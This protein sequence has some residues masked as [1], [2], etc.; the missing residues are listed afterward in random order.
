MKGAPPPGLVVAATASGAGMT[1]AA[2][3]LVRALRAAGLDVRAAKTGPDFIDTAFLAVASGAPAANLD[4]WMCRPGSRGRPRVLPAGLGRLRR[5]LLGP[6]PEGRPTEASFLVVEGAMGLY[7]G[8]PGGAGGAAQLARLLDLPVLLVLDVR[9]M[10]QSVAAL[11]EGFL[12]HS[13]PGGAPRFA[14]LL[15]AQAGGPGHERLVRRALAPVLRTTGLPLVGVLPRAEAPRLAS[16]HLGLVE[17]R[18]ALAGLDLDALGRWF[19]AHCDVPGL[20]R[21]LGL[22]QPR[23]LPAPERGISPG[24]E[25]PAAGVT[26]PAPDAGA[27]VFPVRRRA[28]RNPGRPRVG[29][30][31]DAAF[32]F[33]YADLPALLAELGA[34]PVFF[35]PL[36][37]A[38]PPPGC[39]GLYFPGG[40]PELHAEALAANA[41]MLT[42]LRGLARA[43][44]PIYAECGGYIYLMRELEAAMRVS[45][46]TGRPARR[47]ATPRSRAVEE[48]RKSGRMAVSPRAWMQRRA[49]SQRGP[50]KGRGSGSSASMMAKERASMASG[51]AAGS[52]TTGMKTPG[53]GRRWAGRNDQAAAA[54]TPARVARASQAFQKRRLPS[55]ERWSHEPA[56]LPKRQP[57]GPR[58]FPAASVTCQSGAQPAGRVSAMRR[59]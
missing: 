55:G 16:R 57:S 8:G 5:R 35:S 20:L 1:V 42:A 22:R 33:C 18:E 41:P 48:R 30:A 13:P 9:G 14:G 23:A 37:D 26:P 10:G 47:A 7:D 45:V 36:A 44:L 17:A 58:S 12:R 19:A 29:I 2:M 52:R 46:K 21:A 4:T 27:A 53:A 51:V 31:R 56:T 11:A 40:Y 50:L 34:E 43:G 3:G 25:T 6:V 54:L 38:A 24:A 39:A 15:C 28:G 32:S 49:T 59:L